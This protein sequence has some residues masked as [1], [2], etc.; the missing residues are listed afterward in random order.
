MNHSNR[1]IEFT[2]FFMKF[3]LLDKISWNLSDFNL[4]Y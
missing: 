1:L 4:E 2:I 3:E